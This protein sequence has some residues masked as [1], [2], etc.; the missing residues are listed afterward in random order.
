MNVREI[1]VAV[2]DPHELVEATAHPVDVVAEVDVG[3]EDLGVGGQLAAKLLVV[4]V[5]QLLRSIEHVV[6]LLE[7]MQSG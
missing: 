4:R 3:V 5:E 2:G 6:H 1:A 7:S